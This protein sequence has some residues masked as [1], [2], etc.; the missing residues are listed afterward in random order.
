MPDLVEAAEGLL[1]ESIL[2]ILDLTRRID[3]SGSPMR[4][5]SRMVANVLMTCKPPS[6]PLLYFSN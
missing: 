5:G 4:W 6:A 2:A 3:W 1:F